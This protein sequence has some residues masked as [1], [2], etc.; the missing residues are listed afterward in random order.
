MTAVPVVRACLGGLSG[1]RVQAVVIGLVVLVSATA[2]T[3]GLGLL[4]DSSAP[5]DHAF[6][7]QHGAH[8]TVTVTRASASELAATTRL[9]GVTASA[10]PFP[11][12]SVSVTAQVTPSVHVSNGKAGKGTPVAVHQQLTL[13]GRSSPGGPVDDLALT[14]GHWPAGPGQIVLSSSV[15]LSV[16]AGAPLTVTGVTG[17]KL[18]VTGIATSVTGTAQG[19]VTPSE[20]AALT[21]AGAPRYTQ[22]LYR[23]SDAGT[24]TAV[25]TDISTVTSALP[26]D[27]VLGA[28]SWLD[29][30]A[31]ATGSYAPWVPFIVAFG[32]LG[33][34]MSVLIVINVVSG[35]VVSGFKRI[36]VLKS[37]GFTP[38]QVTAAYVLQVA[39]PAVISCVAGAAAG[40]LVAA[41]MLG[42]AATVY[43]V[44]SL[45]VPFWVDL[46]APLGILGLVVVTASSIALRAGR[47]SAVQAIAT[48]RAPRP[49]HGYRALRLLGRNRLARLLPRPVTIGLAGPFARPARTLVTLAAVSCGVT[50]VIFGFGLSTS[51]NRIQADLSHAASDQVRVLLGGHQGLALVNGQ[52]P[53]GLSLSAQEHAVQSALRA[54]HATRNYAAE[55]GA[56]V[57]ALGLTGQLSLTGFGG[58]ASWAGYAMIAGH[59]YSS[60]GAQVDVN[61]AFL[62][63][64]GAKVG[65]KYTLTVGGGHVLVHIAG[66]VFDPAGG[67]PEMIGAISTLS[68]ADPGLAPGQYQVQVAPGTDLGSYLNRLNRAL[69]KGYLAELNASG[70]AALPAIMGL[71]TAL[72]LVIAVV[73]G[74]GVLNTVALQTR[75]RAHDLGVFKA[76][77]M[78]P[79]QTIVMVVSTVAGTGLAAGLIAVPAGIALHRY[80]LPIMGDAVHTSLPPAVLDVYHARELTLLALTGV[81]I[82]VAGA[83]APAS[84]AARTRPGTALRAE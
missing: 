17:G 44:G 20:I 13:A 83:L 1:R 78:T 11:E 25:T 41:P 84:W 76:L 21:E 63:D 7:A 46:A 42:Q 69:G 5:F 31:Q 3:L 61:T 62:N 9:P 70:G 34:A 82:A 39:V 36:G 79:R 6:A 53:A 40:N 29:A 72:T 19:W 56:Q 74:L 45:A 8:A 77:G 30:K 73:A 51:L 81:L 49:G 57:S 28:Q 68:A 35:A 59:W 12:T 32:L 16:S 66:E 27:T 38:L 64:T 52:S 55:A 14:S 18:T 22:M 4:A 15:G 67:Q 10:G 33:L 2:S 71:V 75:E 60:S 80:V 24:P 65:G 47:M 37:I 23:F 26:R 48:G 54:Q 43:G 50:S 58:D